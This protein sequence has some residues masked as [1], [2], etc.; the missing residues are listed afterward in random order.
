MNVLGDEEKVVRK[1]RVEKHFC[2]ERMLF[3][4]WLDPELL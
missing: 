1:K 3:L 4:Y 2:G